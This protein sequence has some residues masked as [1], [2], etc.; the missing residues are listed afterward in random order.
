MYIFTIHSSVSL[1]PFD[2]G[3]WSHTYTIRRRRR[4]RRERERRQKKKNSWRKN[5]QIQKSWGKRYTLAFLYISLCHAVSELNGEWTPSAFCFV[6]SS[7][8]SSFEQEEEE[9]HRENRSILALLLPPPGLPPPLPLKK[10]QLNCLFLFLFG[11]QSDG[12]D[13]NY[14]NGVISQFN[15]MEL[16]AIEVDWSYF[17]RRKRKLSSYLINIWCLLGSDSL[18]AVQFNKLITISS[19]GP[20]WVNIFDNRLWTCEFRVWKTR[21]M[22]YW[23]WRI[24]SG[25]NCTNK[26]WNHFNDYGLVPGF[27]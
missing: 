17:I 7:V 14:W 25:I 19:W 22:H 3:H 18:N 26:R 5:W 2:W 12:S 10:N 23:S 21:Q 15:W 13:L 24:N 20:Y 16:I 8:A 1:V 4:R 27:F 11:I 6:H 9:I